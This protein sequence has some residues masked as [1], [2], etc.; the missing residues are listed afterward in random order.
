MAVFECSETYTHRIRIRDADGVLVFPTT[1]RFN[2]YDMCNH[3][4]VTDGAMATDAEGTYAYEYDIPDDCLYGEYAIKV[5]ATD[6]SGSKSIFSDSFYVFP[7]K[8]LSQIRSVSGIGE[9]KSIDDDDLA[10]ISWDA[11]QEVLAEIYEY[12]D[13][14]KVKMD[15][16][17]NLSFNGTNKIF[18]IKVCNY[19]EIADRYGDG[20]VTG[21]GETSCATDVDGYWTD[22]DFAR[23]QLKITVID[24]ITGRV[25]LEQTDGTAIP[26]N[27]QGVRVKY[28]TK[29]EMWDERLLR[30][31]VC[32][33]GAHEV[34][35]R[36][37]EIDRVSLADIESNKAVFLANPNRLEKLYKKTL[38]KIRGIMFGG[39]R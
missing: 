39:C 23:H 20:Q 4:L 13:W 36:F 38:S 7:W 31:A 29:S 24:T 18:R 5:V 12:H 37:N 28:F 1:V 15:P 25:T 26:A 2:L 22:S 11:Y 3:Q 21:W 6:A 19:D 8:C 17:V 14:E 10:R 34:T 32:L 16:D 27:H 30:K 33:L 9:R 35:Q